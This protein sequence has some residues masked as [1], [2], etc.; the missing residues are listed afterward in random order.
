LGPPGAGKGTQAKKLHADLGIPHI[1]T[2]DM[3]R[4]AAGRGTELG[5]LAAPLMKAGQLVPDELVVGIALERLKQPDIASGF[6]LDGFPRTIPQ[7]EAL[8]TALAKMGT[9]LDAVVSFE[10]PENLVIERISGRR[11]CPK[12]GSVYHVSQS[13]P[14]RSGFCDKCGSALI[15]REDD[16]PEKVKERLAVYT[17]QTSPLKAYYA[18]RGLLRSLD[19]IGLPDQVYAELKRALGKL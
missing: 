15:Q 14:R 6:I 19:G 5:R 13:P 10:V 17:A 11:G 16:R 4:D 8:D 3:L 1:S 2:G 9:K 12:D 7:G 18:R